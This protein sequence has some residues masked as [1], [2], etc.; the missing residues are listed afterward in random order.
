MPSPLRRENGA[1]SSERG[2][3][4]QSMPRAVARKIEWMI[5]GTGIE[6]KLCPLVLTTVQV[7][8][9]NLPRTPIKETER[10]GAKFEERHGEGAVELDAL[11]ALH[12]GEL[13]RIV[14]AALDEFWDEEAAAEAQ[15]REAALQLAY[16]PAISE[17]QRSGEG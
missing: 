9:Y 16:T 17:G 14:S 6:L 1:F 3:A 10:R 5:R 7:R 4:G 12:P 11:E 8:E 13:G 15:E 2:S